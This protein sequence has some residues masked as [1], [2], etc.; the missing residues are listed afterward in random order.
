MEKLE[1]KMC[2]MLCDLEG[3]T[4]DFSIQCATIAKHYGL[5]DELVEYMEQHPDAKR[6]DVYRFLFGE[7]YVDP[8]EK[9]PGG[10][11][12]EEREKRKRT[13]GA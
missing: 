10:R 11:V 9:N 6:M 1:E 13:H 4:E 3:S 2:D 8:M 12:N 7:P 5:I